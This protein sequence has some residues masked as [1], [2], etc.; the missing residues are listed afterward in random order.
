MYQVS[1][2]VPIYG[3]EKY[4]ERCVRSLFEQTYENLEYIFVD[5]CTPDKS[6]EILLRVM[7][8]Y[9]NRKGQVRII[10]HE[11]NRGL[12]A[13]R[14]TALD[15][16]TSPFISHVDSDDYLSLDAIQLLV[17][18]QVETGSDIVSGNYYII[19]D[20]GI[21]RKIEPN[22]KNKHELLLKIFDLHD[23]TRTV[24][25]RLI[26]LSLFNDNHIRV[27]EG[28]N[29]GEDWQQIPLLAY[30]AK[31]VATIDDFVYY[32]DC[33][34]AQSYVHDYQK[35]IF[36]EQPMKSLFIME[37][38]FA[39]KELLYR[40][41][42]RYLTI[43]KLKNLLH[44]AARNRNK[45]AFDEVK[46]TMLS[47]YSDCFGVIGWDNPLNRAFRCNYP[48]H[49]CYRKLYEYGKNIVNHL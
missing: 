4:I 35:A 16:A 23:G 37:N 25:G 27:Q 7:E 26:R 6:M 49:S 3:V 41:L 42:S 43:C 20:K 5:D 39:D 34:N 31:S 47:N 29:V 38:F 46:T 10:R 15:A 28:V 24:W 48:L 12:A 36:W 11:H 45:H 14:N 17:E 30:Y 33:T 2:L 44:V 32:Y 40:E 21:E 8:D 9:P 19:N 1:I 22:Y 13:A 18:K